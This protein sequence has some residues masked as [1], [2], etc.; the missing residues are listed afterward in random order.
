MGG[1]AGGEG[2]AKRGRGGGVGYRGGWSRGMG[3]VGEA[4]R[5]VERTNGGRRGAG[6]SAGAC[7]EE[8][9]MSATEIADAKS[10]SRGGE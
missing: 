9:D 4:R 1:V 6:V 5:C 2:G 8:S 3:R 7:V 10:R